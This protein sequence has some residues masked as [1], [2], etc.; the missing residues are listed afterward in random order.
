MNILILD[1]IQNVIRVLTGRNDIAVCGSYNEDTDQA[2]MIQVNVGKK[3]IPDGDLVVIRELYG[4]KHQK[5]YDTRKK[6]YKILGRK[7]RYLLGISMQQLSL[8]L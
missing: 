8:I 1:E 5:T 3:P 6:G 2:L 4:L 7:I